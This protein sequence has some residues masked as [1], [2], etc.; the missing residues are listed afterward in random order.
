[1][2]FS[3][4]WEVCWLIWLFFGW[5]ISIIFFL[6]T[7]ERWM[8]FLKLMVASAFFVTIASVIYDLIPESISLLPKKG[9][10]FFFTHRFAG[11]LGNP[12]FLAGY[13]LPH[14]FLSAILFLKEKTTKYKIFWLA[15]CFVFI[16]GVFLTQ[17]RGATISLAVATLFL[18]VFFVY[19]IFKNKKKIFFRP[20][21]SVGLLAGFGCMGYLFFNNF[22]TRF[23]N[24]SLQ[25][26]TIATRFI[27]WKIAILAFFDKWLLGWGPEN[28]SYAFSKFYNPQLLK[29]SFYE[30]WMDKPHNQ[31]LEVFV[32]TGI[33]GGILYILI[34]AY[35]LFLL[36]KLAKKNIENRWIYIILGSAVIA[37]A[38]HIFFAFETTELRLVMFSIF[39]FI[40]FLYSEVF[41]EQNKFSVSTLKK[42][43]GLIFSIIVISLMLIGFK[44]VVASY[45][46]S[47]AV[48]AIKL[49]NYNNTKRHVK[50]LGEVDGPYQ[51]AN[52]EYLADIII[53][54]DAAGRIPAVIMKDI[55]PV[56][57][58]GLEKAVE[59][60][61]ESFS[62]N[63]RLGQMYNFMGI[64]AD[65]SYLDGALEQTKKA[66][67]ISPDRQV[68]GILLG[69]IYFAKRD[70][71][72]AIEILQKMVDKN[73]NVAEPYWFLFILYDAKGEYDKSYVYMTTAVEK[74]RMPKNI[75]D[76]ILYVT[77][78]GRYNDYVRMAP[79]Y[80]RII[81]EDKET[82]KWW[83]NAAV[84][85]F[86]LGDYE[87]ARQYTRQAIFLDPKFGDEGEGFLRTID[88]RETNAKQ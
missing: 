54:A 25:S 1:M 74:G 87:K 11:I 44:T 8:Y 9:E 35:S 49:N 14:I 10:Q 85:Y 13:L 67:K 80:E 16:F 22:L 36:Y 70:L 39:G 77:I 53:R 66:E 23:S 12:I 59:K 31:F 81:E 83:A 62:Y 27:T 71:D 86:E 48:D 15:S 78:L 3:Q 4:E 24:F 40:I 82:P 69:Q 88:S 6:D 20:F 18:G 50:A 65:A 7:K 79:V 43:A 45:Y 38:G 29:F 76:E 84:V 58:G 34:F 33:F 37:Y 42:I 32:N 2:V 73:P 5:L 56:A 57:I 60:H 51:F 26:G 21:V 17:T 63:Y 72:M 30:T 47:R 64:Y 28:F 68:A 75:N 52:W 41:S 46:T 55:V 19:E 61:P